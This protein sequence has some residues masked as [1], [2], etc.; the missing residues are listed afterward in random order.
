MANAAHDHAHLEG[1]S[2]EEIV[3]W[4]VDRHWPDVA[5]SCSFQSQSLPLL[6]IVSRVAPQLP[7]IFLDTGY[8]FPETLAFRDELVER[9][10]LN[11]R[12]VRAEGGHDEFVRTHG[13]DLYRRDP[14]LCCWANKV[15]P[16]ER[17]M[18]GLSAWIS[19]IRRDQ[20]GSRGDIAVVEQGAKGV[21]RVHPMAAWTGRD[22]WSY[23]HRHELPDHPLVAR[24]Y[25]SV[26]CAPCTRPTAAG[27]D[28]RSGRWEG[29]GKTECGLHTLLRAPGAGEGK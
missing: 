25:L 3:A 2:A 21:T 19:G 27:G 7:V 20:T 14:N 8:H 28:E 24:G 9:W 17:A 6:H 13:P 11:L 22:V 4:A 12:V 1:A 29:Q 5:M 10:G 16:M 18:A 26:G 23:I 15:E